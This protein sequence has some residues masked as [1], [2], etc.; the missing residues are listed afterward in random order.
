MLEFVNVYKSYENSNFKLNNINFELKENEILGLIGENGT[1][2][3]TILKLANALVE[4]DGGDILYNKN[5]IKSMQSEALREYRK[6]VSYIFQNANLMQNKTVFYHLSLPY[7]LNN[8]KVD[9]QEIDEM[10][11]FF[12]LS[13]KKYVY[14]N[15][16]S[17]GQKQKIAIAM[18][19]LQNPK[20][21][22]CDEISSALDTNSEK[23]IFDLLKSITKKMGISIII[24][25]HNLQVLKNLCDRVMILKDGSILDTVKPRKNLQNKI[26]DYHQTVLEVLNA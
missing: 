2:K 8:Q 16:L 19:L 17:G 21:L 18:S 26:N 1:G 22:L 11:T 15:K 13:D 3:S 12:N 6:N 9:N 4:L 24:I 23:E 20:I 7:K 25:S 14:C 5:S 10:L